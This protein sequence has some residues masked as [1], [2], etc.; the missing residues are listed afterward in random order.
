[1]HLPA[2]ITRRLAAWAQRV[3]TSRRPDFIIGGEASPYLLRWLIL[4][5]NVGIEPPKVGSNDGLGG[6]LDAA[7]QKERSN[8]DD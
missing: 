6:T 5:R 8:A 2:F 4:P 7:K 3:I 1:M